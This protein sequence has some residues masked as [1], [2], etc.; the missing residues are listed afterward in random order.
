LQ[1]RSSAEDYLETI[2]LLSK[3]NGVVRSVDVVKDTGLSKASVSV[4]MRKLRESDM[5]SV[6]LSVS[7]APT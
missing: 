3:K 1:I 5:I 7:S 4:A 2:L 6:T